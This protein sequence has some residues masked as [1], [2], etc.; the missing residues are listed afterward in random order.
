MKR[1][2]LILSFTFL[3][4][5]VGSRQPQVQPPGHQDTTVKSHV[6]ELGAKI[7]QKDSALA[8]LTFT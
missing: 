7:L 8:A 1:A 4:G 2:V 6:L 3:I 5:S